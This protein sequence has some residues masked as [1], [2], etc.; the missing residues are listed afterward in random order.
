MNCRSFK[1]D[2]SRRAR[3]SVG[4]DM[5]KTVEVGGFL[6]LECFVGD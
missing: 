3:R 6:G 1:S 4:L 2:S 5:K